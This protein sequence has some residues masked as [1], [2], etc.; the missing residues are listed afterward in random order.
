MN[1]DTSNTKVFWK[2]PIFLFGLVVGVLIL[3][4]FL[5][6]DPKNV[7]QVGRGDI[8]SFL[9]ASGKLDA[10]KKAEFSFKMTGRVS[11]VEVS[12]GDE[13]EEGDILAR[14][15]TRELSL[16]LA[17]SQDDLRQAE[18]ELAKVYDEVK[19][20]DADESFAQRQTRTQ[21]E[22]KKDKAVKN[23][24]S[25]KKALS[26]AALYAPFPGVIISRKLE[27]NQWVSAFS[28]EPQ[29][30]LVDPAT[31]YFSAEI[32]EENIGSVKV[33]QEA[34]VSFDTYPGKK[35]NGKVYQI[36]L[37]TTR[38]DGGEVI[39]VKIKLNDLPERLIF[40]IRGDIEIT[41]FEKT[42]VLLIPKDAVYKKEGENF[43]KTLTGEKR[44]KLGVFDG[45]NWE[46]LEGLSDG[47]KI[48][49]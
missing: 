39:K 5:R 26:D 9:S 35:F 12:E 47:Q 22:V 7:Y 36:A 34:V 1:T 38:T 48:K 8:R 2:K 23:V 28:L 14:L 33:G 16:S 37:T 30:V 4:V 32:D 46:V 21:A 27:V 43:V 17:R 6:A 18:A 45:V 25:A 10:D 15:D 44:V 3:Y 49:W 31:V 42:D 20:H 11:A 40:G 29:L 24:E 19:G 13:V 41:F